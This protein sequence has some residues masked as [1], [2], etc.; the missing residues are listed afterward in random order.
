MACPLL[1]WL[2]ESICLSKGPAMQSHHSPAVLADPLLSPVSDSHIETIARALYHA[3]YFHEALASAELLI[4][5][6]PASPTP[7]VLAGDSLSGLERFDDAIHRYRQATNRAPREPSILLALGRTYTS[8]KAWEYAA[9]AFE[10]A[11]ALSPTASAH[12]QLAIC[13]AHLGLADFARNQV[14]R[15]VAADPRDPCTSEAIRILRALTPPAIHTSDLRR[16]AH[17]R[18]RP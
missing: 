4:Q 11:I 13:Y 14:Q 16:R 5:R 12:A 2:G 8:I 17:E 15:A 18:R 10:R 9:E 1:F 6:S 3:G 7:Y